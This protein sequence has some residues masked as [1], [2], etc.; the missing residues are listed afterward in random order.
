MKRCSPI[1]SA[2]IVK[3]DFSKGDAPL[4]EQAVE[5][6]KL[7]LCLNG[8]KTKAYKLF[9]NHKFVKLIAGFA[10][11]NAHL[12]KETITMTFKGRE[13]DPMTTPGDLGM[14]NDDKVEVTAA[15]SGP[16]IHLK[17]CTKGKQST[18][19]KIAP[20]EPFRKL[21]ADYCRE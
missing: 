10:K 7:Q 18:K 12:D 14:E 1:R 6:V 11:Q 4:L 2:S 20:H 9:K 8:G 17:L 5:A 3:E 16:A 19:F 21:K 15:A 13:I